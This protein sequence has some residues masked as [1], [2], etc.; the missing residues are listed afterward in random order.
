MPLFLEWLTAGVALILL[1]LLLPGTYLVWFGFSA[2]T[3][4]AI[5]FLIGSFGLVYQFIL[6][7]VLSVV[8]ALIGWRLY[9]RFI[10]KADKPLVYRHLNDSVAQ[11]IGQI[12]RVTDV[13]DNKIQV[14]IGDTV[15]PATSH[16]ALK[17][18]DNVLITGSDN[19]IVLNVKK[20]IDK[21]K[22]EE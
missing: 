22:K 6:F 3:M 21:K 13:Q 11:Y 2:L 5:V 12:V 20:Y 8:F 9:G 14:S 15:W 1:E 4:G 10:F 19:N 7:G 17:K 16:D 18:G